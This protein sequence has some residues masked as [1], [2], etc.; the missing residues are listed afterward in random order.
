MMKKMVKCTSCGISLGVS[1]QGNEPF[2]DIRC[3]NC[4]HLLRVVFEQPRQ[5]DDGKTVYGGASAAKGASAAPA[6]DGS[7]V[8]G[9]AN[10]ARQGFLR[11]G[12]QSYALR[13]G[14]NIVGRRASSSTANVQIETNDHFM[15]REHSAIK[16]ARVANGSLKA[17]ISNYKNKHSTFVSG[18]ELLDGDELVLTNGMSLKMGNTTLV[19]FEE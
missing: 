18:Q 19:Y 1:Q 3:P 12:N 11:C 2:R 10:V 17:L 13:N 6:D 14:M 7:T 16:M 8:Y 5:E 15:S 9:S 4:S